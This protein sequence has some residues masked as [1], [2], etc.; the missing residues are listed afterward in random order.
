MAD[1]WKKRLEELN[2]TPTEASPSKL[3]STDYW[4][5]RLRELEKAERETD[6]ELSPAKSTT[7]KKEEIEEPLLGK[8]YK[9]FGEFTDNLADGIGKII[10]GENKKEDDTDVAPT[11][12]NVTKENE[13]DGKF[14]L[15]DAASWA[16]N[17]T[18]TGLASFNKGITS[19]ADVLLGKPLQAL[20][21]ENNPVSKMADYYD[22]QYTAWKN[23]TAEEAAKLGDGKGLN[24]AGELIEGTIAAVP[25][26][27]AAFMSGGATLA[28]SATSA[29]LQQAAV[30]QSGNLLTKIGVTVSNMAKNPQ[31]WL[32]FAQTLGN[33]YEEA[34]ARGASDTAALYGSTISSLLNAGVEIGIDGMSGIEGLPAKVMGGD[35]S[36][37][38]EWVE[39]S[40]SEGGEEMVQGVISNIV[41]KVAYDPETKVFDAAE[42]GKEFAM[43]TA[44]GGI[45]GGAQIGTMKAADAVSGAIQSHE[46]S[47]LTENEQKVVD[48]VVENRIA[49]AEKDGEKL[50]SREK[51]KIYDEVL[52]DLERGY[53][54]TDTIEEVL[55]GDSYKAYKYTVDSEDALRKEFDA[56]GDTKESDLTVKQR[57]RYNELKQKIAEMESGDSRNQLK[58][59]LGGEVMSLVEGSRLAESYNER[60]RR[61]EQFT[62][63]MT[64]YDDKQKAVVQKA[65]DSGILNNTNRT[66]EFVDMVAKISADKGVLF[67]FTNN[68]KLKDSGFAVDGAAVNGYVTKDGVTVNIDSQ[69]S[70][71]SV[72]GHEITHVLEG[73]ELYTELQK[74][75]V[76]YAK[77]KGDYQG[78]YDSL[79]ALYKDIEGA[80]VDAELTADLVGD[81]LFTDADFVNSLSVQN[82]NVFQKIYDE[83]KYL[84]KV[85]TAGSK[86]AR[87][88]EKVKRAFDKAYK[89]SGKSA[90]GVKYSMSDSDG[91]QL[92][93]EQGE[94]FKDSKMRDADG[95]LMVM[96]HGS[97]DAGFHVF[98]PSVSDD[99]TSLFFVDRNDV[100]ASYSGTTETYEAQSIR[101]AEDMNRFME[102]IGAQGYEV[103]EKNGKFTLLYEGDRVADSDTA[104]GIYSEFCWY[105]GVGEGDANYKVYLNL[106]NPLEIDAEGRNWNNITREFSQEVY[107]RYKNLTDSEKTAL[108]EIAGWDEYGIFKDEI[109]SMARARA[110]GK[111]HDTDL[112]SAYDKLGG[113]NANLYD[114][115][116]IAQ[117]DFSEEALR[118]FAVKQMNTRDYAKLA[119]EQGYDGVIFKNIHDNGGYSNGSEGAS[120]VAIAFDS[121]QIKSVANEKPTTDKDIRYSM[122]GKDEVRGQRIN[123][124]VYGEDVRLE[125]NSAPKNVQNGAE[126]APKNVREGAQVATKE[127]LT[128]Q[129]T[130]MEQRAAEMFARGEYDSDAFRQLEAEYNAVSAQLAEMQDDIAPAT[131]TDAQQNAGLD[132]LTDED[133]PPEVAS[134]YVSQ[135]E[136]V[137]LDDNTLQRLSSDIADTMSLDEDSRAEMAEIIRYYAQ[138]EGVTEDE[139]AEVIR[140]NFRYMEEIEL[141]DDEISLAK[142]HMRGTRLYIPA[143]FKGDFHGERADGYNAFRK[144]HF[145]HFHLTTREGSGALSVGELYDELN[146]NYPDLFPDSIINEAERLA[147]MAKIASSD[148]ATETRV[149]PYTEDT[150]QEVVGMIRDGISGY[151]QSS[152]M[153]AANAMQDEI[154]DQY[155]N[156]PIEEDIAPVYE[157]KDGQQTMFPAEDDI[158]PVKETPKI[159]RVLV[160]EPDAKPKG[161]KAKVKAAFDKVKN[162]VHDIGATV[163]KG[164]AIESLSL[165]TG[166]RQLQADYDYMHRTSAIAQRHIGKKLIP[167]RD[168]IL[169]AEKAAGIDSKKNPKAAEEYRAQLFNYA[170][171]LHNIDRMSLDKPENIMK[172]A[173]LRKSFEGMSDEAIKA[174]ANKRITRNTP[175]D[176][177]DLIFKA[178]AYVE[179]LETHNKA[180][181]GDEVTAEVS[182]EMV[183][184][185]ET[186]HPEFKDIEQ[187][188]V[189]YNKELREMLVEGGLISRKTADLWEKIYPHFVPIRR[190]DR[191][192]ANIFVPLDTNRTGVNAPVKRATGGNGDIG[193]LLNTMAARTEQTYRALARNKF[194]VELKNTLRNQAETEAAQATKEMYPDGIIPAGT[195]VRA[196]DRENVGEVRSYDAKTNT[197]TV[198]FE[199][200]QGKSATVKLDASILS[201]IKQT[202]EQLSMEELLDEIDEANGD[203]LKAG[204]RGVNP[205]FTVFENGERVEFDINEDIYNALKPVDGVLAKRYKMPSKAVSGFKKL[206]TEWSMRFMFSNPIKDAQDIL[207]NSQHAVKTYASIPRAAKEIIRGGT[208]IDEYLDHGG[209]QNTYFDTEKKEFS[210]EDGK[211]KKVAKFLPNSV[212]KLNKGFEMIPRL[213]EYIASRKAGASIEVAML[214]AA[215]VTTNFNAG[216]DVVKFLNANFVPFLNPSVQ[217]AAQHV[218]NLRE[219]HANSA[220]DNYFKGYLQLAGKFAVSTLPVVLL[221]ALVWGDDE[222]YEDLS[223]YVKDNYYII[224]K[225]GDGKF[226]RLPKGRTAAVI[227]NAV[228]Q[229]VDAATGDDAVDFNRFYELFMSNI[230]PNSVVDNNILSTLK[231]LK[232]NETWYGDELVPTRLQDVPAA[233]Q[234]DESIDVFSKWLG[235]VTNTSPYKINYLID[236]YSGG[237]GDVALP[238]LTPEAERGGGVGGKLIA[239][240]S[241]LFTTDSTMKNQNVSDFYSKADELTASANSMYATD[242]DILKSKYMNSVSAEMSEL[243][244]RKR[245]IQN[246]GLSDSAKYKQVREIQNQIDEL[247]EK[248]LNTYG[249]ISYSNMSAHGVDLGEYATIGEKYF[250]RNEKTGAW[251]KLD[252]DAQAKYLATKDAGDSYY[253]TDGTNQYRW[254]E[255]GE[256]STKSA[257]WQK[258]SADELERQS[259]VTRGLGISENEYW[260]NREEYNYAYDN[261][262]NYQIARAVGGFE[263]YQ[264]YSEELYD[265]KAD[266]DENGKSI[267]GSQKDKVID[268]LNGLDIDY[269]EK[270]ILFK[271]EYN[272][273]DTYNQD[274][275]DYLNGRDDISYKQMET[276]LKKL[277]F[278]VDSDGNISW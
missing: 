185:L 61:G 129:K 68:A 159:A 69:K 58:T 97:Q 9:G 236:Q 273:D 30:Y 202:S 172:R 260:S 2:M 99:G 264:S 203:L 186:A 54:S 7:E 183:K 117:G 82:R 49:E 166:N 127:Q 191:E 115:F 161:F 276:I 24:I 173:E 52:N 137:T 157:N 256:D 47:K 91:K 208:F 198:Y 38:F 98:D 51:N 122:S 26:A 182:R 267:S 104:Q 136:P 193:D 160:G 144:E 86:E 13:E 118:E 35:K 263:A 158:A 175:K 192:G 174:Y 270:I 139:L 271:N 251:E 81:Y 141:G 206:V 20:G 235:G 8:I 48:A 57:D 148:T 228:Q 114:A 21:W 90:D 15:K 128:A 253:A 66:H 265:I 50:T 14:N 197:Y 37:F 27:L 205:T 39:S 196:H 262:E 92:T 44:V 124:N 119:K 207:W 181:F 100:A 249:D 168:A 230:A 120:T 71:N 178:Q 94:Y 25:N 102:S 125:N 224:A 65:I 266:K 73:T 108:S 62:A 226:I 223:D 248:G 268:Y 238:F 201:P 46:E 194:G 67:D 60:G 156:T 88:L 109:L 213:A 222:D 130:D 59:K 101:T 53:I 258:I 32:S 18:M 216:G 70:L 220:K 4:K 40:L 75:V 103:V 28:G 187:S 247:A 110:N 5:T 190:I 215:R 19:T 162:V 142:Q 275:I 123:G 221:N 255:P 138:N 107:D 219:A 245:E 87:E 257:G 210:T 217:G 145:G 184:Q 76:E 143:N 74:A 112:A 204:K 177:V 211:V 84:Y 254:Y 83:I 163:D 232:N 23:E 244:K 167:I 45:L 111:Y 259:E 116:S 261:P 234:Y 277:G 22:D 10:L 95:N 164:A 105:E 17:A 165:K 6:N 1:Y 85:A 147:Q 153:D 131:E 78:R 93:Q 274:I 252:D 126:N 89:E 169:E 132:G 227:Q 12:S 31:Y 180:V 179:T 231:Q 77:G 72:V 134:P 246:S 155:S 242:D 3:S 233:E 189:E 29:G 225:Y 278:D 151:S 133:T 140:R 154:A 63:D 209:E 11:V 80:D 243:Y 106:K 33:D 36:A 218:R 121:A 212:S 229:V 79:S 176:E 200:K 42:M 250:K 199:N 34:K 272:A 41:S 188:I 170:Y 152:Q 56:L 214:D 43:G 113:A 241:D 195:R 239:P 269:Y 135:R 146:E 149:M 240:L 55:G 64:L 150:V 96:Y 16:G 237:I 171:H